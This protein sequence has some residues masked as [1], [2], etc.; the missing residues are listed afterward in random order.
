MF[1]GLSRRD[2]VIKFNISST[3]GI[4]RRVVDFIEQNSLIS[5]DISR[6]QYDPIAGTDTLILTKM[7]YPKNRQNEILMVIC[8]KNNLGKIMGV[9]YIRLVR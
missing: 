5:L 9:S 2:I 3:H 1:Q 8:E 6:S 4:L 7:K